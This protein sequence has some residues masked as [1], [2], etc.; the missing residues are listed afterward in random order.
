MTTKEQAL[1]RKHA[2]HNESACRY[3]FKCEA[4][5]DWVVTTAFYS[6]LHFVKYKAFPLK[7]GGKL[8]EDFESYYKVKKSLN[9]R[10]KRSKHDVIIDV[11]NNHLRKIGASYQELHDLCSSARY[12]DYR[13]KDADVALAMELFEEIKAYCDTDK[14]DGE[15]KRIRLLPIK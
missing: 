5:P 12:F 3:L 15:P 14:S 13:V 8:F 9:A 10:E 7:E 1:R 11:A 6:S 4:Y 2:Q